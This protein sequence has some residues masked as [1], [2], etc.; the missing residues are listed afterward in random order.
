L[1]GIWYRLSDVQLAQCLYRDLLF[2]KFCHLE[3]TANVQESSTLGRFLT[4][5][6]KQNLWQILFKELNRQLEDKNIII[7]KGQINITHATSKQHNH[8]LAT[9]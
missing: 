9:E 6:V 5:L 2:R 8:A 1:L 3:L 7:T 4:K